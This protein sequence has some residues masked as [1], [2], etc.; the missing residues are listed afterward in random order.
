MVYEKNNDICKSREKEKGKR[1]SKKKKLSK[2]CYKIIVQISFLL[3]QT[4][5]SV[6]IYTRE[7]RSIK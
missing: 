4:L 1:K 6:Y 2:Y 3:T 5:F 7:T